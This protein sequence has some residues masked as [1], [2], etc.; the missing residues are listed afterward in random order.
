MT[1]RK[2]TTIVVDADGP[3]MNDHLRTVRKVADRR[4]KYT[5]NGVEK[6]MPLN[7]AILAKMGQLALAGS[8]QSARQ[9]TE[10]VRRANEAH[11]RDMRDT[12]DRWCKIK[13]RTR[14]QFAAHRE[15]YG[16]DPDLYPHPDDI[17]P[18]PEVGVRFLGPVDEQAHRQMQDCIRFIDACLWQEAL[19]ISRNDDAIE[20]GS[21]FGAPIV[22]ALYMNDCLPQRCQQQSHELLRKLIRRVGLSKRALLKE[23]FQAWWRV[24]KGIP[25]GAAF[26]QMARLAPLIEAAPGLAKIATD[27]SLT[28]T[29]KEQHI[30][31]FLTREFA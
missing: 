22:V 27:P 29:E 1:R 8:S 24:K 28:D 26:P 17:V 31:A 23:T 16:C 5:E 20:T 4:V 18:D 21:A 11:A 14:K 2:I 9:F 3:A 7:E 13:S 19:D 12:F 30:A 10:E 6:A 25:R 15:A